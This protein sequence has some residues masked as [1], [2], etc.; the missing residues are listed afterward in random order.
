MDHIGQEMSDEQKGP[1]GHF[2]ETGQDFEHVEVTRQG[3]PEENSKSMALGKGLGR[4]WLG[5]G[6][7]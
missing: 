4:E 6:K 2:L 1:K 5:S 7:E 3:W